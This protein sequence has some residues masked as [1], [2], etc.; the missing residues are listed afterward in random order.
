MRIHQSGRTLL[1]ACI[2][3]AVGAWGTTVMAQDT[4]DWI[5]TWAASAQPVWAPDFLAPPKVP[6][7]LWKQTV[8]ELAHVS[9]GGSKV[10]LLLT[11][12]YTPY[13]VTIGAV[14]VAISNK[15]ASILLG[16]DRAVTFGGKASIVIPP[17]A[18]ALSDPVDLTVAPLSDLA[19]SVY[20]P[21]VTPIETMHW[22]GRQTAYIA[23]GDK[24]A[25]PDIK[26]DSTMTAKVFLS[27]I[28]VDAPANPRAVVTFGD[29]ITDGDGSTVDANHRWPDD[30]AE[31]LSERRIAVLNEGISGAK[32]LSDRM[33]VNALARFDR[34]VLSQPHADVVTMMM[35][36]N[37]IGWP[38]SVLA[39][40][41]KVPTAEEVIAGHQQIIARAHLHHMRIIGATLTP[42]EDTFHGTPLFGYYSEEKEKV[43]EAVN[44]WIRESGAYDAIADFDAVVR[45]PANPKHLKP[46]Y[47]SGDHL[48]PNDAGYVAMANSINLDALLGN[49]K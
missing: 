47:D 6:R 4:E 28:L 31:R 22:E 20:L 43:R 32:V 40:S 19:V 35:G 42:F 46:E 15:G 23:A 2:V 39:P 48:H 18:P 12:E 26:P 25:E 7:N 5:G 1:S 38:D 30:L 3:A 24:T 44:K 11:N 37:D 14:H 13:P 8:R 34:D 33:G 49:K 16:S 9:I 36:I 45:D 17:G 27:E 10:R 21:N 41:D 29:S